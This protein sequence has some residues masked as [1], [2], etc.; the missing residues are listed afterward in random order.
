MFASLCLFALALIDLAV[1]AYL[2]VNITPRR[3]YIASAS[4]PYRK[5]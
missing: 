1:V 2:S 4:H 3:R 5:G